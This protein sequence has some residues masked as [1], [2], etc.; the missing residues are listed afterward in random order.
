[1][2]YNVHSCK[3]IDKKNTIDEIEELIR[4]ERPSVIGLN[5]IENLS[6]RTWFVNQPRRLAQVRTMMYIYGPT[7]KLGRIGLFGNAVL[8][9]YPI[10]ETQNIPLP[11]TREPRKCL[12][13]LIRTPQGYMTVLSTHLGLNDAERDQQ[14]Q[15]LLEIVQS[16][17]NPLILMGDFNC[18]EEQ[19]Q[20]L[21]QILTDTGALFGSEPTYQSVNPKAR[22]DYILVSKHFTCQN[23]TIPQTQ[24]S[25]HFPVLAEATLTSSQFTVHNSQLKP[26][27]K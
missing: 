20:P 9:V 22:I 21:L 23:F 14:I 17:N 3:D 5:E 16:E 13:A 10:Y 8:S 11:G 27:F 26:S 6:P 18:K 2:T 24:A 15:K 19:L 7:L 4:R 12:K 25:D 1:M